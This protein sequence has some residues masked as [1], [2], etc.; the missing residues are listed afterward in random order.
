MAQRSLPSR[1]LA[2]VAPALVAASFAVA[3]FAV[4]GASAQQSGDGRGLARYGD[5]GLTTFGD[6]FTESF[7]TRPLSSIGP[8]PLASM[9]G[10]DT[11]RRSRNFAPRNGDTTRRRPFAMKE[12]RL[13]IDIREDARAAARRSPRGRSVATLRG[14]LVASTDPA[15]RFEL[16]AL[17]LPPLFLDHRR[18]EQELSESLRAEADVAR[19]RGDLAAAE[20][21]QAA[22]RR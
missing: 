10:L 21:L 22:D 2:L 12:R 13:V 20:L 1:L 11:L 4:A 19:A 3:S 15:D 8:I 6:R 9:G 5:R 18:A 17:P 16:P 14:A 7:G